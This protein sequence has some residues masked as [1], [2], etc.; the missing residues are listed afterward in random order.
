MES[1]RN[2]IYPIDKQQK[3]NSQPISCAFSC[4]FTVA[5]LPKMKTGVRIYSS[6]Q[7]NSRTKEHAMRLAK[8]KLRPDEKA[9][10]WVELIHS[11][12]YE[13]ENVVDGHHRFWW[14]FNKRIDKRSTLLTIWEQ[15]SIFSWICPRPVPDWLHYVTDSLQIIVRYTQ[16]WQ[17]YLLHASTEKSINLTLRKKVQHR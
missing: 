17:S 7:E 1:Q 9:L 10:L 16:S 6:I 12:T 4:F 13:P 3:W 15:H 2:Y 8:G 5:H 11:W 14:D